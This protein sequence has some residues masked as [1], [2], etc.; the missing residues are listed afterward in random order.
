MSEPDRGIQASM[1]VL[2]HRWAVVLAG[3]QGVRLR[4]L[5]RRVCGDDR[6]KQ[7][8]RL[9]GAL[10][11]LEET[12]GRVGRRIPMARTVV[13]TV[14]NHVR[15]V[16]Q[17]LGLEPHVLVQPD[18]RGT[19]AGVLFPVHWV[20]WR[21][22]EATV[23]VCPSDHFVREEDMFMSH[24]GEVATWVEAHP[25]RI[26]LLGAAPT[27][28]EVEYGWIEPGELVGR[29]TGGAIRT[30][31]RFWEKP[32][33]ETATACLAAGC[34][35]NTFVIVA[36]ARAMVCAG[37]ERLPEVSQRL[38]S[39]GPF[40]GTETEAWAVHQ[41]YN[42]MPV[43]NFSRAVLTSC[44]PA[45]VVSALPALAWSDLGTPRRVFE[46]LSRFRIAPPWLRVSGGPRHR[47]ERS[48]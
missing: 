8:V 4:P 14:R 5:V 45:L 28:P 40:A 12:L 16:G 37:A 10:T 9:L 41:A 26:V 44:P 11:L 23:V 20:F 3:G 48:A 31:R 19:G 6:P 29:T 24:V 36:K 35:W 2:P 38:A 15:F 42:L 22:P 43:T 33:L 17:S 1:D 21:D 32:A 46:V 25:E 27:G 34:F 47:R 7:Y 13:V 18:D 30:I 39:I